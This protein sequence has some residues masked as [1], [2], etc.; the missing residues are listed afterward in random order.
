MIKLNL[1]RYAALILTLSAVC[2]A[3]IGC[4]GSP[5]T[6]QEQTEEIITNSTGTSPEETEASET[7]I[8]P[9]DSSDGS[10]IKQDANTDVTKN[11]DIVQPGGSKTIHGYQTVD[12]DNL[13]VTATFE[14]ETIK[15]GKDAYA[16]LQSNQADLPQP[17]NGMEY[18]VITLNVTYN[19]G[20]ADCLDLSENDA[21]LASEKTLFVLSNGDSNAEPMTDYLSN[22]IYNLSLKKGESGQGAVAFLHKADSTEPLNL[23][24]FGN[25]ISFDITD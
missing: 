11:N 18:I 1:F 12:G 24:G 19:D 22:S 5:K 20:K 17:D 15:R 21:S 13:P 9:S 2:T 10:A 23:I 3:V 16:V 14:L 7:S 6:Q 4:S 8:A 25:I